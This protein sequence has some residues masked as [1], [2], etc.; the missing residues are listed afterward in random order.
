[1]IISVQIDIKIGSYLAAWYLYLNSLGY[2]IRSISEL[3]SVALTKQLTAESDRRKRKDGLL[4]RLVSL[5][6]QTPE[7]QTWLVII[8]NQHSDF[9]RANS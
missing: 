8:Q 7:T 3:L 9:P 4:E 1:M 5:Y 6:Y 2:Q